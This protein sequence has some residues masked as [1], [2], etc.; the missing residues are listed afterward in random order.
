MSFLN[1]FFLAGLA[2][3]AGPLIIHLLLRDRPVRRVLPTLRFLPA[4]APE[5][6]AM[7]R[8]KNLL[9]LILRL[10]ILALVVLA[11]ARP[12]FASNE[13]PKPKN[14]SEEGAVFVVDSSLSMK[15][16]KRWE[17]AG[18]RLHTFLQT[19]PAQSPVALIFFD[20]SPRV[21]CGETTDIEAIRNALK[22][23]SP[24]FGGTDILAAVRAGA[25]AAA[26]MQTR[27]KRVYLISDFQSTGFAQ[28]DSA[29]PS[30][31]KGVELVPV[32][33]DSEM[34][35]NA[36]VTSMREIACATPGKRAVRIQAAAYGD[37]PV[38]T[39]L[40]VFINKEKCEE[41]DIR[42]S[43]DGEFFADIIIPVDPLSPAI[44]RAAIGA[45]DA[46]PDDNQGYLVLKGQ[47]PLPVLVIASSKGVL[48]DTG[49]PEA[50][51]PYLKAAI[52]ACGTRLQ[53]QWIDP[54]QFPTI[55]SD[56]FSVAIAHGADQYSTPI[57]EAL[58][59][60]VRAGGSLVVFPEG[61]TEFNCIEQIAGMKVAS[62]ETLRADQ[63]Q[64]RLVTS[65]SPKS[66]LSLLDESGKTML[67]HPRAF[68]YL[69]FAPDASIQLSP[70]VQFD[71]GSPFLIERK[72]DKGA[73]YLFTSP[74]VPEA[75]DFVLRASFS[76]FLF[77]LL[78]HCSERKE[79]RGECYVDEAASLRATSGNTTLT[80]EGPD[81]K[82]V[83]PATVRAGQLSPGIY[84]VN[85]A[86]VKHP[87][88]LKLHEEESDLAPMTAK[89]IGA[90]AQTGTEPG[91]IRS[92][93]KLASI[94][95]DAPPL[96][97]K[98]RLWWYLLF[99]ALALMAVES[100][101]ASRTSR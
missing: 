37:E 79:L 22:A 48:T 80:L 100:L 19:L 97:A 12:Y 67:G 44:I 30:I 86:G 6:Y 71:D 34:H 35:P 69:K 66:T 90:L 3:L 78:T 77:Q 68:H 82:A 101:L 87:I 59:K 62:W 1:P 84:N 26:K 92:D 39:K 49:G 17:T 38:K 32:S 57:V 42:I 73:I 52:G 91:E 23:A 18:Q 94:A 58:L 54:S 45:S 81:G 61:C 70:L 10:A 89:R 33:V 64:Y 5:S 75:C 98:L 88:A 28:I 4:S 21:A 16:N 74:P 7:R 11:F 9:L 40:Q 85:V 96:D 36:A 8:V 53:S 93:A 50:A 76:P 63:G 31:A 51:N 15:A 41:R 25:D 72:L 29:I 46:L 2:A 14:L 99:A 24:S 56:K 20:R 55:P 47:P 13:P 27:R 60:F 65:T 43:P 95:L 83:P